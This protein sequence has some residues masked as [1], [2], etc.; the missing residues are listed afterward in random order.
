MTALVRR[1]LVLPIQIKSRE[2]MSKLLLAYLAA[3]R[4]YYVVVGDMIQM[5]QM[6]DQIPRGLILEKHLV[7]GFIEA[8][9]DRAKQHQDLVCVSD[10]EGIYLD[11]D[12]YIHSRLDL[13]SLDFSSGFFVWG[14]CQRDAILASIDHSH[15]DKILVT[16]A[17][18]FDLARREFRVLY[19][20]RVQSI[21]KKF[22][23]FILVN[24]SFAAANSYLGIKDI[25]GFYKQRGT[26]RSDEQLTKINARIDFIRQMFL[27]FRGMVEEL[28]DA[29]PEKTIV[30]RPHPAEKPELWMGVA[31]RK[32]NVHVVHEGSTYEW[33]LASDVLIHNNC[34]TSL[35][36]F[37]LQ[38]PSISYRPIKGDDTV[39]YP[40]FHLVS[41]EANDVA[42]V[43]DLVKTYSGK[44]VHYDETPE[45]FA[46]MKAYID[47]IDGQL[48][49]QRILDHIDAVPYEPC[50]LDRSRA[51]IDERLVEMYKKL[52]LWARDHVRPYYR[53][54]FPWTSCAEIQQII[55]VMSDIAPGK[56]TNLT[57]LGPNVFALF[58]EAG[59]DLDDS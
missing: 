2:L 53:K 29:F 15:H 47:N 18:R 24:S 49:C 8:I 59:S 17:P 36:A 3:Q 44:Q 11:I 13:S 56:P 10:E 57:S 38:K 26:L 16:G 33:I 39:E 43:I 30:I 51:P 28:S 21:R 50:V 41:Y 20:S 5:R 40:L 12:T 32:S 37:A 27:L 48:A 7:P 22:Q 4:G 55:R 45:A 31:S 58:V 52:R 6:V 14:K 54:K 46:G 25:A 19:S 9:V 23:N 42:E 35:E 34:T 1:V